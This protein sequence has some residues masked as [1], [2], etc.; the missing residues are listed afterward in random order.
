MQQQSSYILL[1]LLVLLVG[2]VLPSIL[3]F[4][5]ERIH[6]RT[7]RR[8]FTPL[9]NGGNSLLWNAKPFASSSIDME[10]REDSVD[11]TLYSDEHVVDDYLEFLDRRYR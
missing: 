8:S 11:S 6:T 9:R 3:A 5:V 4:G 2:T 10:T 7:L 1:P